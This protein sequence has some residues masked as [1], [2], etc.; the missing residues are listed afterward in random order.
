M[1]LMNPEFRVFLWR[2]TASQILSYFVF[3][4][5]AAYLFDYRSMFQSES[6]KAYLLPMD[7]PQVAAGPALQLLRGILFAAVLWPFRSV[8]LNHRK[9]WFY[10]W[11]LFVG[12]AVFGT[13]GPSP[14]SLEAVIYTRLP[15]RYNLFG[16]PEILLQTLAFSLLLFYWYVRSGVWWNRLMIPTTVIIVVMSL[17]GCLVAS[18]IL[19]VPTGVEQGS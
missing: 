9:G 12:L 8:F 16:L 3:G 15:L 19:M 1:L 6:L 10:L 2:V 4:L 13:A 7:A 14:G 11:L 18:G 5:L 17:L